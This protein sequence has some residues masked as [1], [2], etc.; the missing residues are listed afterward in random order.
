VGLWYRNFPQSTDDEVRQL[1]EKAQ[2]EH[3]LPAH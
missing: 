3:A 2:R 1:L